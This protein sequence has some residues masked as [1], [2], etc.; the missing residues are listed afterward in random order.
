MCKL[1]SFMVGRM[2]I[3][4]ILLTQ[5]GGDFVVYATNAANNKS[6]QCAAFVINYDLRLGFTCE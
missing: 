3:R 4:L 1:E 2:M 6:H 5:P